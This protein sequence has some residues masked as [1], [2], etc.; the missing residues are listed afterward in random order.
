MGY[1]SEE[2]VMGIDDGKLSVVWTCNAHL[3]RRSVGEGKVVYC[4]LDER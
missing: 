2:A 4:L 1:G 3:A